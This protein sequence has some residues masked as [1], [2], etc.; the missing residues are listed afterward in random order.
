MYMNYKL[1][2]FI[3]AE[4]VKN[5]YSLYKNDEMHLEFDIPEEYKPKSQNIFKITY[6]LIPVNSENI[7]FNL[8]D[9]QFIIEN[10]YIKIDDKLYTPFFLHPTSISIFKNWIT[11]KYTYVN[12]SESIFE[13]TPTSSYRS[14]LIHNIKKDSYFIAKVSMF[15]NVANGARQIDWIS[16]EGQFFFSTCTNKAVKKIK[17]FRLLRDIAAIKLT[18]DYPIHFSKRYQIAYGPNKIQSFGNVI[19]RLDEL[20]D[21]NEESFILSIAS[22]TSIVDKNDCYL[23][24]I[25]LTSQ[26]KFS[27]FFMTDLMIPL[28]KIMIQLFSKYGISLESHCQNTLLEIDK[29]WKLTG[30][31]YYRDFDI[32]CFDRGRFPF[33]FKEEWEEYVTNRPDRTSLFSNLSAREELGSN[34]FNYLIGNLEKPCLLCAEELGIISKEESWNIHHK[35]YSYFRNEFIKIIPEYNKKLFE[36]DLWPHWKDI[37]KNIDI[38][39]IPCK[40]EKVKKIDFINYEKILINNPELKTTNYYKAENGYILGFSKKIFTELYMKKRELYGKY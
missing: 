17:N 13:A 36:S 38:S 1:R 24:K 34:F 14:L 33:I 20:F 8:Q 10:L 28:F 12:E 22:I 26:K 19:R 30:N 16:A 23:K 5:N 37:F 21:N 15:G 4:Q 11:D 39:E 31:F 3:K 35:I 9:E 40:L 2:N 6:F 32:T 27:D 7:K 29:D 18:G 25:Y